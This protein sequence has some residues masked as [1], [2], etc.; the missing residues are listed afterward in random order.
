VCH[1]PPAVSCNNDCTRY[2]TLPASGQGN[3]MLQWMLDAVIIV[4]LRCHTIALAATLLSSTVNCVYG[5][6]CVMLSMPLITIDGCCSCMRVSA[7]FAAA[8]VS[9]FRAVCRAVYECW[10]QH[11]AFFCCCVGLFLSHV[12]IAASSDSN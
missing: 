12:H 7:G 10:C 4:T 6:L 8:D 1:I 5:S 9:V 2:I 11:R 3:D